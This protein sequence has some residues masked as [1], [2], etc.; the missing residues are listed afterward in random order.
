MAKIKTT[1]TGI[2]EK[3]PK[4]HDNG[5]IDLIFKIEP[6]T[7]IPKGLEPLKESVCL[8]HVA[9]KT[10]KKVEGQVQLESKL[11][12]QGEVTPRI[13]TQ[14]KLFLEMIAMD[15]G[16]IEKKE[17]QVETE[18]QQTP[19]TPPPQ[20]TKRRRIGTPKGTRELVELSEIHL[21]ES[22]VPPGAERIQEVIA[23]V[24][25]HNIFDKPILLMQK[26]KMLLEG[27]EYHL[28]AQELNIG[29]VPV[30]YQLKDKPAKKPTAQRPQTEAVPMPPREAWQDI[31]LCEIAI[32][33]KFLSTPSNPRSVEEVR[34]Y[35]RQYGQFDKPVTLD[36]SNRLRN[37]YKR[38]VVAQELQMTSVPCVYEEQAQSAAPQNVL[39]SPT[40][41]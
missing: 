16:L 34:A 18:K 5:N 40:V 25:A 37:G 24:E 11:L 12:I 9:P 2:P 41:E 4:R 32:L 7:A 28:V 33:A 8:V 23:Y 35:V 6:T 15:I 21:S 39:I 17:P 3:E 26:S 13:N 27:Y 31:P 22:L 1:L 29:R 19:A 38:Y 14:G 36:A 20:K 30:A 10:W